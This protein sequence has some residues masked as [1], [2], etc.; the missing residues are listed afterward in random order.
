MEGDGATRWLVNGLKECGD[1]DINCG[2][3]GVCQM[4]GVLSGGQLQGGSQLNM[5]WT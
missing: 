4:I 2:G 1:V 5:A 3:L